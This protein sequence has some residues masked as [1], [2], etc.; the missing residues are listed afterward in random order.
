M[1]AHIMLTVSFKNSAGN[2]LDSEEVRTEEEAAVKMISMIQNMGFLSS[3]DRIEID[4]YEED[5]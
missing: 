5:E 4:G 3:G 2:V 1:E